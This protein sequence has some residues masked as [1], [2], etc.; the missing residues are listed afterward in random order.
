MLSPSVTRQLIEHVAD[1]AAASRRAH[2]RAQ[3]DL[4]TDREREVATAV[5]RG[6]SNAEIGAELHMSVPTVKA[7]VSRLLTKL[8]LN[9][10]VQ[11]ALLVHDA[12]T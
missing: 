6:R 11:I 1:P 9:N 8:R 12:G 3:L 4:L 5:G 7:P 2:A 10:R